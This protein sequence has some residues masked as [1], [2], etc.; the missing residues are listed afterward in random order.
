M[1]LSRYWVLF[2]S[3]V[4]YAECH[5]CWL[6]FIPTHLHWVSFKLSVINCEWWFAECHFAMF[7]F[8][9]PT[10]IKTMLKSFAGG[11]KSTSLTSVFSLQTSVFH[12]LMVLR[13]RTPKQKIRMLGRLISTH[14]NFAPCK[15]TMTKKKKVLKY[16]YR[17]A[18]QNGWAERAIPVM[19]FDC[20]R[21]I[22]VQ[23]V[24]SGLRFWLFC[25]KFRFWNWA[26]S[27]WVLEQMLYAFFVRYE[28]V[29]VHGK[30]SQPSL[31]FVGKAGRLPSSGARRGKFQEK[32]SAAIG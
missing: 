5:F 19:S 20:L 25:R 28:L 7:I 1:G 18:W 30:L 6:P 27:R 17:C 32:N 15:P 22:F 8:W 23:L 11:R 31:M 24:F 12:C 3:S 26:W 4:V 2:M 10:S 14:P 13:Q 29:F 9:L 16:F 21:P